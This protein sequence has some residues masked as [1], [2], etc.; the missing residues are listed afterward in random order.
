MPSW[1]KKINTSFLTFLAYYFNSTLCNVLKKYKGLNFIKYKY[2]NFKYYKLKYIIIVIIP[3]FFLQKKNSG[4]TQWR[5][6][7]VREHPEPVVSLPTKP[8]QLQLQVSDTLLLLLLHHH[9]TTPFIWSASK[10]PP[11]SAKSK[12]AP[13]ERPILGRFSS[14]LKIGIVCSSLSLSLSANARKVSILTLFLASLFQSQKWVFSLSTPSSC[15][16]SF[17]H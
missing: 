14:H 8:Y 11:K 7:K 6:R 16:P 1:I 5:G 9:H 12:E 4:S 3:F 15:F 13:A 10:M 2:K 17:S